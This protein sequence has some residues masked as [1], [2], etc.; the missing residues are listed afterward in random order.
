MGTYLLSV[1]NGGTYIKAAVL[2]PDGSQVGLAR[3]R[4]VIS[5]PAPGT[6][7]IDLEEF[8]EVNC[9]VISQVL[10]ETG[11]AASDIGVVGFSGQGKGM[12]LVDAAGH[13][14]FRGLT[15][16]DGRARPYAER[17]KTDGTDESVYDLIYQGSSGGKPQTQLRWLKDN[18]RDIYDQA[19]WCFSMK[20]YLTF[21]L[22]GVA[23]AGMAATSTT[24]LVNLHTLAYD[25][26]L[27]EAYGIEEAFN[28]MPPLRWDTEIVGEVTPEAAA[29]T[30]LVA[31]T[32][33][34][35]G[36]FDV[37]ASAIA[38][39]VVDDGPIAMICGTHG[40]NIY[41]A[42]EPVTNGSVKLNSTYAIPGWYQI[43][44]GY[45]GSTGSLEWVLDQLFDRASE[46]RLYER[47]SAMVASVDPAAS[48]VVYLPFL[49][50]W[51]DAKP[52]TGCFCGLRPETGKPELL[53]AAYEGACFFHALQI[54]H[55]LANRE[56][57]AEILM[58]GGA[59]SSA[60]WVQMFADVLRIPIRVTSDTEMG[61]KGVAITASVAAGIHPS[62]EEA[63]AAMVRPGELVEPH[64]AVEE[65]YAE[66]LECFR[67]LVAALDPVWT[68]M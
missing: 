34:S 16:S 38:M 54:E 21:R 58:A 43:E 46:P 7:E 2:K 36:M 11:I 1:D 67:A 42:R 55:L 45:T 60:V 32:P 56:R 48:K 3:A 9:R 61:T 29:A 15:S 26:R 28:K 6:A 31:G 40:V 63:V 65:I 37:N 30:G 62:I 18:K 41:L 35:A 12:Y 59:T 23:E 8:W 10:S 64:A 44:E 51:R 13:P 25:Q 27:F 57:P 52:A 68:R 53:R 24:N 33:V 49:S 22:T 4:N 39:G 20:D 47:V 66:K 5:H 17:W 50:G 14:L 19:R